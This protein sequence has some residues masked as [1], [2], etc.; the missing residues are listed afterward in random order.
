MGAVLKEELVEMALYYSDGGPGPATDVVRVNVDGNG[1]DY[2]AW[3]AASADRWTIRD[4][5]K[6]YPHAQL[7]IGWKGELFMVD[8]SQVAD[9]QQQMAIDY[10]RPV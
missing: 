6:P 7:D 1:S 8:A 2:D 9:I 5:W 3:F 10:A 4:G